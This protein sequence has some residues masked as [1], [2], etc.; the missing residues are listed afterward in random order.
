MKKILF[1]AAALAS[2]LLF[3]LCI[4]RFGGEK[5]PLREGGKLLVVA[6]IFPQY[7]FARAVAGDRAEVVMLLPPGMESHSFDPKPTDVALIERAGLFVYTGEFMEPWAHRIVDGLAGSALRVVDASRGVDMVAESHRGSVFEEDEDHGHAGHEH[8]DH[9]EFDPHIWLNPLNAAIMVGN[10]RD[11]LAEADPENAAFYGKNAEQYVEALVE[12]DEHTAAIVRGGKRRV[13]AFGG[14]FA[15]RY[16]LDRYELLHVSAYDSCS[17]EA[18]PSV[19]DVARVIA[20]IKTRDIP[21]VY[22]E[23]LAIPRVA[24]TIAEAGGVDLLLFSTAHNVTKDEF[25]SGLTFLEIMRANLEN[26]RRGLY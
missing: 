18:E 4:D 19:R 14:R 22:H 6:S 25:D 2:V 3:V 21:C 16:F 23:E 13:L 8:H 24:R 1:P 17:T 9:A 7:D 5:E 20:Y 26:V 15:Y 11:A 12:L 10:I